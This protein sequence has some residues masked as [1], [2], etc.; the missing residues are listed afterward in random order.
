[1]FAQNQILNGTYQIINPLGQGGTS[2]V[3]L[4]YHLRL[5]KYVVIKQIQGKF[6]SNFLMRTEVDILKNLHHPA[7]PQVYD[8]IQDQDSVYTVIDFV[9]GYDLEAYIAG[10]SSFP[11]DY[12]KHYLR[13]I[14]EALVYLHE[15]N[16]PVLHSDIKPGNIMIDKEGNANLIDFNIS[17]GGNYGSIIGITMPYA[18]PEQIELARCIAYQQQPD[19]E[20][21]GRSDIY[22]LGATFYELISGIRPTPGVPPAPLRSMGLVQYSNDFLSLI[23]RMMVYDRD[24]RIKSAR[25]LVSTIDRMD[26]RY[27]AYFGLRCASILLSALLISSG[28]YCLIRGNSQRGPERFRDQIALAESYISAGH[29]DFAE[30]VCDEIIYQDL[31]AKYI[32]SN[33]A[34]KAQVYHALGDIFYYRENYASAAGYYQYAVDHGATADPVQYGIYLRDAAIA[35]AQAGNLEQARQY[36]N[37]AMGCQIESDHL[38]L[39]EMI[40]DARSGNSG[41]CLRIAGE[42]LQTCDQPDICLR[43]SMCA[44]SVET[45]PDGRI[46]WLKAA[47]RYGAGRTVQ[48]R[49]A[50]IYV[51]KANSA[52]SESDR[53]KHLAEAI[54]IYK[55]LNESEYVSL[56]DRLNYAV[57]LSM[58]EDYYTTITVLKNG[59]EEY[60][61]N[62]RLLMNLCFTYHRLD[63][64]TQTSLYCA[65]AINA[66]KKDTSPDKHSEASDEIQDLLELGRRYGIGG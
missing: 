46:Q 41:N 60:P 51:E 24:K 18:S 64:P 49:I 2:A 35:F 22:S 27:R 50:L 53:K 55:S 65:A 25:K 63:D 28:I 54:S 66:W 4:A 17:L 37:A 7:L 36:L 13:Q 33:P 14:A 31:T 47:E 5:Q 56:E 1:M 57:V 10:A 12:L 59:L 58:A 26:G 52:G 23:D 40:I 30:S 61:E 20:L 11:E 6:S 34:S 38:L 39:A 43:A 8:F 44:A 62:Y 21:D 48:R 9:D 32:Q 3:Y 45:D 16:P 19:F 29:L 15:Q 42:L